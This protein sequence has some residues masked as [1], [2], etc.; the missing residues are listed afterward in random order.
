MKAPKLPML[1][2]AGRQ[3]PRRF[4]YAPRVY[5]ERK[6]RLEKRKKEIEEELKLEEKIK[7]DHRYQKLEED[8]SSYLRFE[9]RRQTRQSNLRLVVILVAL[10]FGTYLLLRR[11]DIL[12]SAE[13]LF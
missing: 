8:R 10:L 4:R 12:G 5:D 1:F 7:T 2:K 13:K 9:R 11:L 3:E 6:E